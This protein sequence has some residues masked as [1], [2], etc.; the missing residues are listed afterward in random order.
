MVLTRACS[1]LGLSNCNSEGQRCSKEV[2]ASGK[3]MCVYYGP[4]AKTGP[5]SNMHW[6][7]M[8]HTYGGSE[9]TC[10]DNVSIT[11]IIPVNIW[12][13]LSIIIVCYLMVAM[14]RWSSEVAAQLSSGMITLSDVSV[15]GW[16]EFKQG[17]KGSVNNAFSGIMKGGGGG[18]TA[19]RK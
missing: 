13:V 2:S 12:L 10:G 6:Y 8:C 4:L 11:P 5:T 16:G 19:G 3:N 9:V 14:T 18:K 1:K 7:Q 17:V 15:Q